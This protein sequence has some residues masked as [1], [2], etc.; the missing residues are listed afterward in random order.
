MVWGARGGPPHSDCARRRAGAKR[1]KTYAEETGAAIRFRGRK[2]VQRAEIKIR[3]SVRLQGQWSKCVRPLWS[4]PGRSREEVAGGQSMSRASRSSRCVAPLTSSASIEGAESTPAVRSLLT[5]SPETA[6]VAVSCLCR[7]FLSLWL[8]LLEDL[9]LHPPQFRMSRKV[10][11]NGADRMR[12]GL[13]S[14]P[15]DL[16]A[17]DEGGETTPPPPGVRWAMQVAG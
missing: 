2:Q 17:T 16:S 1:R 11:R 3:Y 10:K 7:G 9:S 8:R 14:S 15:R 5:L 13:F 12:P 4:P 6:A